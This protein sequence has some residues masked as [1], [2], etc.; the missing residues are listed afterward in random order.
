[1]VLSDEQTSGRG[2]FGRTWVSPA[3]ENIYLTLVLRPD[4]TRVRRLSIITAL[5]VAVAI[6]EITPLKPT[7]KWPNDVRVQ[8]RKLAGILIE[9]EFS[10]SDVLFSLVGSGIN[11]NSDPSR[12][13]EIADI[14]TSI[15]RETGDG[16]AREPI[17][18]AFLNH[19]EMFYLE[20]HSRSVLEQWKSRLDTLGNP[21]TV[22]FRKQVVDGTA[23]DVDEHGDLLVRCADGSL[24]TVIAGEV[25]LRPTS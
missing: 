1:V 22:V 20:F 9:N 15:M 5:A 10:G 11:V 13:P 24:E 8:G 7:I 4:P 16:W 18:S 14:A 3:G 19:F 25:S 17:V 12:F 21:V 2:R 23:E 6:E